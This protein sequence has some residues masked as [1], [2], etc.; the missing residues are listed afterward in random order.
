MFRKERYIKELKT[1]GYQI[2]NLFIVQQVAIETGSQ[3]S[4]L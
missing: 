2:M 4:K 1:S 3:A